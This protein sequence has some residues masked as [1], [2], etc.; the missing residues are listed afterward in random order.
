MSGYGYDFH[1][2]NY[3]SMARAD[4]TAKQMVYEDVLDAVRNRMTEQNSDEMTLAI[5]K[6]EHTGRMKALIS[7]HLQN[8]QAAVYGGGSRAELVDRL[9]S[10]LFEFSILSKYLAD[11]LVEEINVYGY[12]CIEVVYMGRRRMLEEKF[13]SAEHA[14][15]VGKRMV[16]LHGKQVLDAAFPECDSFIGTGIRIHAKIPPIIDDSVGIV[17]SIRK[18]RNKVFG[19]DELVELGTA[20]GDMLDFLLCVARYGISIGVAGGTGSGKTADVAFLGR[21][22][23]LDKRIYVVEDTRELDY[24]V[25]DENGRMISRVI[26]TKTRYSDK[27]PIDASMLSRSA[28]RCD[29]DI[30]VMSEMRGAEALHVQEIARTGHMV[31]TTLHAENCADA[32]DRFRSMCEMG[33]TGF[34]EKTLI[35]F[36]YQSIPIM[37]YKKQLADGSRKYMEIAET[38]RVDGQWRVRP[39][40]QFVVT[41]NERDSEGEAVVKTHGSFLRRNCISPTLAIRLLTNGA[42]LEEIR[43]FAGDSFDPLRALEGM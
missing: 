7:G 13:L 6:E 17:M 24:Y 4:G 16:R 12:D 25:C 1:E 28:L 26:H 39:L 32:Y 15:D 41:D 10:D 23:S 37:C 34:S 35:D 20:T 11:D 43:H 14:Q 3:S 22:L 38:T 2:L 27:H 40:W 21:S 9:Y 42:P 18:Q 30:I 31:L 29:P 36:V 19:R 5:G 8:M 33:N